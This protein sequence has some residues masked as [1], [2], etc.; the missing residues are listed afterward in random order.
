[1]AEQAQ[2]GVRIEI[3]VLVI[4]R[5]ELRY[6]LHR[7]R[8]IAGVCVGYKLKETARCTELLDLANNDHFIGDTKHSMILVTMAVTK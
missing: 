1:M 6:P 4:F 5:L 3:S 7:R 2:K 8:V